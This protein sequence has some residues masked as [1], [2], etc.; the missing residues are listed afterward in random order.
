MLTNRREC[1]DDGSMVQVVIRE[2]P[3][4]IPPCTH[5]YKYRLAFVVDG[6][7]VVRYDN[8]RGKGDH[9]HFRQSETPY[10]F[11]TPERLIE[12]FMNDVTRWER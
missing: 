1:R 11:S 7:C 6:A 3:E 5:R 10:R 8:E 9:R 4:A 12:D 2:V